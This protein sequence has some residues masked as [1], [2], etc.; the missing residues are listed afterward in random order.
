M[1][2]NFKGSYKRVLLRPLEERDIEEM[3]VL[4]NKLRQ[5]FNT[6][7]EITPEQ[8][9]AWYEKY[10]TKEDD[11]MFAAELV[12]KPGVFIGAVGSYDIDWETG[13][14]TGGRTVIDKEKAPEK[15]IGTEMGRAHAKI[16]FTQM[17]LKKSLCS[18]HKDNAIALKMNFRNGNK[19]IGES[20]TEYFLELTKE[21]AMPLLE[22]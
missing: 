12:E 14:S 9:K 7:D 16:V 20:E 13:V 22:E 18:V 2:H 8:Q 17:G 19:I 10:L 5:Y 1:K 4:R 15:G 21:D 3:R 11:V 6:Q